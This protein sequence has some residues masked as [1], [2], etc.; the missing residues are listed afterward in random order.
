MQA[1]VQALFPSSAGAG[2]GAEED[3]FAQDFSKSSSKEEQAAEAEGNV[4]PRVLW[5]THTHLARARGAR[6][7]GWTRRLRD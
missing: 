7:A 5:R 3:F 4:A 1:A 6:H 2:A